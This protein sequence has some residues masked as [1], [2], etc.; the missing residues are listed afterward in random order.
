MVLSPVFPKRRYRYIGATPRS[1][2]DWESLGDMG[3]F[4]TEGYLYLGDR[5]TDMI[6]MGGRNVYP[7]EIES[8]LLTLRSSRLSQRDALLLPWVRNTVYYRTA[9]VQKQTATLAAEIGDAAILE[10]I[11][12]AALANATVRL[13]MLLE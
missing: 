8:A 7:A 11:G 6:L 3:H 10:A 1:I 13:A 2:G 4:D 9:M 12:V 5:R